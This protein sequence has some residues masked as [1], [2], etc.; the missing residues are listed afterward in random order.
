MAEKTTR[1][2]KTAPAVKK[3]TRAVAAKAT[4]SARVAAPSA[5]QAA[6]EAA[7]A[8]V[9][10]PAPKPARA[11]SDGALGLDALP[12]VVPASASASAARESAGVPVAT[13]LQTGADQARE[14]YARV[15]ATTESLRQAATESATVTTRGVI[16]VNEK[17]IDAM[18]AQSDAAFE[19]W[20]SALSATSVSEAIRI[21]TTGARQVYETAA[22]QWKDIAETTGRVLSASV[23]P[24]Q[25]AWTVPGR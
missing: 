25:S 12:A 8:S 22:S 13:I 4:T 23:K 2:A 17:L 24:I 9:A 20:R 16:E 14:A 10:S 18:R 3:A 1:K 7:A 11:I 15:K 5:A 6:I 21:Q 19:L